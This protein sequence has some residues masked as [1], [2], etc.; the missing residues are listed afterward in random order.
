MRA[1]I[2]TIE[3][4]NICLN[5]EAP[6]ILAVISPPRQPLLI[7][8]M[9]PLIH[10]QASVSSKMEHTGSLVAQQVKDSVWSLLWLR[11]DPW[12][13]DFG[14]L[15]VQSKQKQKQGTCCTHYPATSSIPCS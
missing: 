4:N 15:W 3:L 1:V 2:H 13:R 12:P 5:D 9:C 8:W 14:M 7:T 10:I 11:F 6:S